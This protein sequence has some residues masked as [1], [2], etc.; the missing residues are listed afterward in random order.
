MLFDN[1]LIKLNW[2]AT[3]VC[4]SYLGTSCWARTDTIQAAEAVAASVAAAAASVA[5]AA[6]PATATSAAPVASGNS[7]AKLKLFYIIKLRRI[8][9]Q[10]I[11]NDNSWK[12]ENKLLSVIGRSLETQIQTKI[13][14]N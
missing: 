8:H 11:L 7:K 1:P 4:C 13:S 10:H 5:A 6:A 3:S 12:K 14:S 9:I 2:H